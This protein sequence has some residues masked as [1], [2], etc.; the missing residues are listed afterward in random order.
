MGTPGGWHG[1]LHRGILSQAVGQ[2]EESHTNHWRWV[3]LGIL[4][5]DICVSAWDGCKALGFWRGSS[6]HQCGL[7]PWLPPWAAILG[8]HRGFL[9]YEP[10][11][12][13]LKLQFL[14]GPGPNN[15]SLLWLLL[16]SAQWS[17]LVRSDDHIT[18]IG[19]WLNVFF[20]KFFRFCLVVIG[21]FPLLTSHRGYVPQYTF[22][23]ILRQSMHTLHADEAAMNFLCIVYA[24]VPQLQCQV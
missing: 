10:A 7:P 1:L 23:P 20:M 18:I 22:V 9:C 11:M 24:L 16:A 19:S 2:A 5:L 6:P 3:A 17:T 21:Q 14:D 12:N 13:R 4:S 15:Y 8:C